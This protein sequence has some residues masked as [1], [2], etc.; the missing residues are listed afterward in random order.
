MDNLID[1]FQ[2]QLEMIKDNHYL[3]DAEI[4]KQYEDK[5][6]TLKN[7]KLSYYFAKNIT[8]ANIKAHERALIKNY[9]F[10]FYAASSFAKDEEQIIEKTND[11]S[12]S[13][14]L[15]YKN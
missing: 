2:A 14:K 10:D 12:K 9:N 11:F 5:I 3:T 1:E 8:G 6:L 7:S 4:I 15:T 13:R